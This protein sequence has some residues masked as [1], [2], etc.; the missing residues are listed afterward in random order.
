MNDTRRFGGKGLRN[1]EATTTI[2][3]HAV[4]N[5]KMEV[6][7]S[8]AGATE[9]IY[10]VGE[11][12]GESA[13]SPTSS[14]GGSSMVTDP[15]VI[16]KKLGINLRDYEDADSN[17][18]SSLIKYRGNETQDQFTSAIKSLPDKQMVAIIRWNR[19]DLQFPD[20][21]DWNGIKQ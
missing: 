7:M 5:V 21:F 9:S 14:K 15:E 4:S 20:D 11:Q 16:A 17:L 19:F 1:Q 8:T 3:S 18:V 2:L 13:S 12:Q 10:F 6:S